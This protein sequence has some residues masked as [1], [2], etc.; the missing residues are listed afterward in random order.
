MEGGRRAAEDNGG[1]GFPVARATFACAF[2]GRLVFVPPVDERC[3]SA[4]AFG[5]VQ[6]ATL[7]Y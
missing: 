4:I 7:V 5:S 6:H 3:R 2:V 1:Q